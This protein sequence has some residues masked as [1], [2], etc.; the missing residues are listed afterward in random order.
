MLFSRTFSE[1]ALGPEVATGFRELEPRR[2]PEGVGRGSQVGPRPSGQVGVVW[3]GG[4][5]LCRVRL[6]SVEGPDDLST[7]AFMARVALDK[8]E[9]LRRG[10]WEPGS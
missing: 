5:V 9:A 7:I 3:D 2:G 6:R 1:G 10:T 8:A 4:C